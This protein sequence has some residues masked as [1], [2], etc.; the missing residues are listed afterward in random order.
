MLRYSHP[1]LALLVIAAAQ[2]SQSDPL[3]AQSRKSCAPP[4]STFADFGTVYSACQV[5]KPA[6]LRSRLRPAY[7][8]S[9]G[10]SIPSCL[11]AVVDAVIDENG[12]VI[13][14]SIRLVST[15]DR[16][17]SEAVIE[18]VRMAKYE[19]AQKEGVPVRQVLR[20]EHGGVVFQRVSIGAVNGAPTPMQRNP[21]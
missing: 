14:P 7:T 9:P 17:F 20:L 4:D 5:N 10:A 11:K 6:K 13:V 18:E 19:A 15:T 3:L 16:L 2:V 8:P 1:R 12:Q 21:C